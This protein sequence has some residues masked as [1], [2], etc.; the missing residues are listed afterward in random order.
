MPLE[1]R[2]VPGCNN[3][4]IVNSDPWTMALVQ[5]SCPYFL[6]LPAKCLEAEMPPA[7]I[8][9]TSHNAWISRRSA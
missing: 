8:P 9:M 5:N 3:A 2:M 1:E 6:C 4:L 7:C